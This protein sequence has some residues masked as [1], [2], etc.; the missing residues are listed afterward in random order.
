MKLF[1]SVGVRACQLCGDVPNEES[2]RDICDWMLTVLLWKSPRFSYTRN[3][4]INNLKTNV[5]C[6]FP[7]T[8][9]HFSLKLHSS[10]NQRKTSV[11]NCIF[12]TSITLPFNPTHRGE[13]K[14]WDRLVFCTILW[15]HSFQKSFTSTRKY[16]NKKRKVWIY[17]WINIWGVIK[18]HNTKLKN[19]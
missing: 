1:L 17:N 6:C 18:K 9:D 4:T 15:Q 19:T 12:I 8:L 13:K 2:L 10:L 14:I 11:Y 3:C 5:R 16:F 7:R